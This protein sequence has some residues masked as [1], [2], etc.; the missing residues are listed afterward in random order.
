MPISS[1]AAAPL[2]FDWY[3]LGVS[4]PS[5]Q[6]SHHYTDKV[7]VVQQKSP[8]ATPPNNHLVHSCLA[9][10]HRFTKVL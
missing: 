8:I 10:H 4:L 3:I 9:I 5:W 7:K 2:G 1:S 6:K